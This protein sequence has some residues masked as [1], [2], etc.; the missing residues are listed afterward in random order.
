MRS[1]CILFIVFLGKSI[2]LTSNIIS[3][4]EL[5]QPV[6]QIPVIVKIQNLYFDQLM[7]SL[8]FQILRPVL[9]GKLQLV[10]SRQ[11]ESFF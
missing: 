2:T 7:S 1:N 3:V 6:D 4:C 9:K 10:K 5:D 11:L 8:K